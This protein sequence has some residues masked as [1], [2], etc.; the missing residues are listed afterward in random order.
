MSHVTV[1][2]SSPDLATLEAVQAVAGPVKAPRVKR[3][4]AHGP[5]VLAAEPAAARP[6]APRPDEA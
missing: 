1:L 6:L 4:A 3:G 2:W 5:A